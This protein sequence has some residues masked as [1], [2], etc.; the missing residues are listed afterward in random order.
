[1]SFHTELHKNLIITFLFILV[2]DRQEFEGRQTQEGVYIY[3][4][5]RGSTKKN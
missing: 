2:I 3:G 1:M 4:G 5:V